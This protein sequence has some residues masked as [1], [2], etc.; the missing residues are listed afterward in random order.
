MIQFQLSVL[1]RFLFGNL[2]PQ[3][4][5]SIG[6]R[7]ALSQGI[8]WPIKQRIKSSRHKA[9]RC[10]QCC[11][12]HVLVDSP[13]REREIS[14]IRRNDPNGAIRLHNKSVR[15][16]RCGRICIGKR[17]IYLSL[18]FAG[19]IAGIREVE[20]Q[21]WLV[22]FLDYDLGFFDQDEGRVEPAPNPFTPE[23]VLTMSPV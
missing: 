2:H 1:S 9:G 4:A 17:K 16:T 15:V 12:G 20:N 23:R 19:Q 7:V 6:V 5:H 14:R 18:A 11:S 22:S 21:I 3:I 8:I 10:A 13:Q